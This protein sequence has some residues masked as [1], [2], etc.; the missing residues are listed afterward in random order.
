[1]DFN[2]HTAQKH[3]SAVIEIIPRRGGDV[4]VLIVEFGLMLTVLGGTLLAIKCGM[5]VDYHYLEVDHHY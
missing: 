2:F 4:G 5:C 3:P 1:M